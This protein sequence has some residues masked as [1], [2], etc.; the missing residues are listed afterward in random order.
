MVPAV[1]DSTLSET[2]VMSDLAVE[3]APAS[4]LAVKTRLRVPRVATSEST[5]ARVSSVQLPTVATPLALVVSV[6]PVIRPAPAT[7]EKVTTA[8]GTTLLNVSFATTD[9]AMG[10]SAPA[11]TD[12]PAPALAR[13]CVG[14]PGFT[15]PANVTAVSPADAAWT[16]TGP[17]TVPSVAVTE[18]IPS[19]SVIACGALSDP[20]PV[21]IENWTGIPFT[22][23]PSA[24]VTLTCS[25]PG[26]AAPTVPV[27]P[28]PP[29]TV[30]SVGV[31]MKVTG[32]ESVAPEYVRT[33]TYTFLRVA[34]A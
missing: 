23:R 6:A 26:S 7:T 28:F 22:P 11:A 32:V 17:A 13:S 3:I 34:G 2:S 15:V 16:L 27:W 33:T 24:A 18:A 12:W 29:W 20:P 1:P 19:V 25:G 5:C 14:R 30:R 10:R 21:R 4:P 8:P 31:G 9:G